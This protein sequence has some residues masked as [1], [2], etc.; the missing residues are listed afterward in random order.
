MLTKYLTYW[1]MPT[2]KDFNID[3]HF[4]AIVDREASSPAPQVSIW[5]GQHQCVTE[6]FAAEQTPPTSDRCGE[7]IT[8][9]QLGS[10]RGHYSVLDM[11]YIKFDCKGFPHSVISQI[12][13]HHELHFLVASGRYTG[14][15]FIKCAKSE[16]FVEEVF[17]LRPVG[18]YRDR[19]GNKFEYTEFDRE[20]DI[21]RCWMA[22]RDFQ[23][24]VEKGC[25]YEM[26]RDM[27]PYCFRQNF[28]FAG[29]LRKI[30]HML[31][32]RSKADAQLEIQVLAKLVMDALLEWCPELANWYLVDRYGKAR[33]AP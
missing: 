22:C 2:I 26:A 5:R 10:D 32:Q 15:R 18:T 28:T 7:I 27:M 11:A 21:G 12:T 4:K 24:K 8:K 14:D 9:H 30:F 31:D 17:Y 29:T 23:A 16:L 25:P 33:L 3:R 19:V 1:K 20:A 6:G 13:R